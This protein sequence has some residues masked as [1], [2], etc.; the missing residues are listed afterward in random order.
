[1]NKDLLLWTVFLHDLEKLFQSFK[2]PGDS[3]LTKIFK[4]QPPNSYLEIVHRAKQLTGQ[5]DIQ[6]DI[7]APNLRLVSIFSKV[8]GDNRSH[9]GNY[10]LPLIPLSESEAMFPQK[11]EETTQQTAREEFETLLKAFSKELRTFIDGSDNPD[12]ETFYFLAQKY[13]WCMPVL[14]NGPGDSGDVSLFEHL[15]STAAAAVILM[16]EHGENRAKPFALVAFDISGIQD[17]IY[18]IASKGAAR[19]L[20]GRSFYIQLL[21]MAISRYILDILE[22][23]ITN[24]I[25]SGGGKG[26]IL[27]PAAKM[28][29]APYMETDINAFLFKELDTKVF[30]GL[31][32]ETF[33]ADGFKRFNRVL[34]PVLQA[35][36]KKK[37]QKFYSLMTE[38]YDELFN[39]PGLDIEK[40]ETCSICGKEEKPEMVEEG[41]NG[42]RQCNLA[43]EIGSKLRHA[44]AIVEKRQDRAVNAGTAGTGL[45][46]EKVLASYEFLA[47]K[48]LA[49]YVPH[50][51]FLY[52]LNDTG[53]FS[54]ALLKK[55]R[56]GFIFTAGNKAPVKDNPD[57][58][59]DFDDIADASEG[60]K[61]LGVARGDVDNLGTIFSRGLG[62]AISLER[63]SQLS[64][65]L[66]HFFCSLVN[67]YFKMERKEFIVYSGGDDFFIVGPW[68]CVIDDLAVFR[69]KFEQYTG[70]N[71]VFSFSAGFSLFDSRYPAFKFAEIAGNMEQKAKENKSGPHEKNSI[72]FMG[73]TVCWEDFFPLQIL[74]EHLVELVK[75]ETIA[76]AYIQL[77]QRIGQYHALGREKPVTENELRRS[78]RFHRWKW[79]YT[80]QAAR[81][82]ERKKDNDAVRLLL[83]NMEDFLFEKSF[84]GYRFSEPDS[85]YLIEMPA[86][87]A[88][89]KTKDF[90][91]P[92]NGGIL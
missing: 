11:E 92:I 44:A 15:K 18:T 42:C 13:L 81:L 14:F 85:L 62:Q 26:I 87:W 22:L 82:L 59:A 36:N 38:K 7:D 57:E 39:P 80:W 70:F 49:N 20:K 46:F 61:K 91:L 37:K 23:P 60:T 76:K 43:A 24:I 5:E 48:D 33:G 89:L 84:Q 32:C 63:M 77:L 3:L 72:C 78:A 27:A 6:K 67:L 69:K 21:E 83:K 75:N 79:Y 88:E 16:A 1:M 31:A 86:R 19:S 41:T 10:F 90:K 35:L 34:D 47:E 58:P 40:L 30:I 54:Q 66:K 73:K 12:F 45:T 50:G 53:A 71:P 9:P 55:W 64:F 28:E 68:N 2:V 52:F 65:L 74:E 56:V 29:L 25:Y 8:K 4:D 51:N 17:F